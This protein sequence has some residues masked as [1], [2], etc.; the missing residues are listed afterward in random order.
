MYELPAAVLR[1]GRQRE[2]GMYMQ[3]STRM[4]LE[5]LVEGLAEV[6]R[7]AL[8]WFCQAAGGLCCDYW[9]EIMEGYDRSPHHHHQAAN[10][11]HHGTLSAAHNQ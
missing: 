2:T 9:T 11:L 4:I 10:L 3:Q 5:S 1:G 6:L 8:T 7:R